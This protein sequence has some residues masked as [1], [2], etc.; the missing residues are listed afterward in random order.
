MTPEFW[1]AI[2]AFLILLVQVIRLTLSHRKIKTNDLGC[3]GEMKKSMGGIEATLEEVK[4][5]VKRI[6]KQLQGHLNDHLTGKLK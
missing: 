1:A 4:A 5:D 2:T 3:I 6:D